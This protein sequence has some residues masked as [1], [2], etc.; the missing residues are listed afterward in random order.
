MKKQYKLTTITSAFAAV[1]LSSQAL[2]SDILSR[3][4]VP[5]GYKVSY[6]AKDVENA[7]QMAV[8]KDGT[9]YVG[10]RKAGK[11]HALIDNNRDGIADKKILVAEGLNMPSGIALKDGDLYVAE[12]ERII[13][14][15][16][17]AKNLKAP[18]KDVVFDDLPDKRHHAGSISR[19]RQRG[20]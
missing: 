17:I 18:V 7:R 8:G 14:F 1:L 12:V 2:A 9:V 13:R 19:Y 20:S 15:K 5:D 4:V 16:Q 6:F 10:S 11:V 3:L